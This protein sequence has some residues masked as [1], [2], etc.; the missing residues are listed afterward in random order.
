MAAKSWE[1]ARF[2]V[3]KMSASTEGMRINAIWIQ[4]SGVCK[5]AKDKKAL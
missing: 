3:N 5:C 1:E 2:M 4:M